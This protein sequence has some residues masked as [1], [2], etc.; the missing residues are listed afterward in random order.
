MLFFNKGYYYLP[1]EFGILFFFRAKWLI[2]WGVA[3]IFLFL[4]ENKQI[5][6]TFPSLQFLYVWSSSWL[7]WIMLF[8]MLSRSWMVNFI[9]IFSF[10]FIVF[11]LFF[12]FS[13]LF[14]EQLR[15]GFI[16]HAVTS[17]TSWWHNHKTD[18]R[19]RKKEVE[20]FRIKWRHTAWAI[21]AGLISYT[22]S[23]RVGCAVV[24]MDHE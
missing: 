23:F 8:W 18:H 4:L 1:L 12:F 14:L 19:T 20:G 13:F 5:S 10:Y 2:V 21:Y 9:F 16:S 11:S 15:L 22:W 17:V 7:S 24:S 6:Y 3:W